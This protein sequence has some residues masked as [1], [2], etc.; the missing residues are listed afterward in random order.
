MKS[1]A[2]Q[3]L[4]EVVGAKAVLR[5]AARTA[6]GVKVAGDRLI[7]RLTKRA[8]DF[9]AR[10]T[11]PYFCPVP[12]DLPIDTG[13][14]RGAAPGLRPLLHRR[15][16]AR[17][18]RRPEAEPLL[19][20]ASRRTTSTASSSRSRTAG[21][22]LRTRSRQASWTPNSARP[23]P[24]LPDS[25]RS[26]ASTRRSSCPFPRGRHFLPGHEHS[27]PL[28]KNNPKLRQAVNFAT[29]PDRAPG[30]GRRLG[31][32]VASPTAISR[33]GCRATSTGTSTRSIPR[34]REGAGARPRAHEKR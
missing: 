21:R 1:P 32:R 27:R 33:P 29:R 19:P 13:R 23:I 5:G 25:R 9:P 10:M 20:R 30:R 3:Y 8:S 26:T 24:G 22:R 11:M 7:I 4:Q 31:W 14:R 16:R 17:P 34:S 18:P 12:T 2:A 15:V 6:A 28:F